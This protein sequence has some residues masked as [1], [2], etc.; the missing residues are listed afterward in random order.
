MFAAEKFRPC[1]F[2]TKEL[3]GHQTNMLREISTSSRGTKPSL[4]LQRKPEAAPAPP[5]SH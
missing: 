5:A 2:E 4:K 1:A 3:F